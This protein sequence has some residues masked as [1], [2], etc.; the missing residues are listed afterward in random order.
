MARQPAR[1][2]ISNSVEKMIATRILMIL[3]QMM[4]GL[5]QQG[6]ITIATNFSPLIK[7]VETKTSVTLSNVHTHT[8]AHTLNTCAGQSEV[9]PPNGTVLTNHEGAGNI[10]VN[11]N[12]TDRGHQATTIW[13][14]KQLTY[15]DGRLEIVQ[16]NPCLL[17]TSPSPRDATLSRMPSSA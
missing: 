13:T 12:V 10:T 2:Q 17:Y 6:E 16:V 11:C 3:L 1:D 14:L 8:H 4:I 5:F 9:N 15:I 7:R